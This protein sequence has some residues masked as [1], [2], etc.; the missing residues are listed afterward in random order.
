MT[1]I[2]PFGE[3]H[4]QY[5]TL[6]ESREWNSC[7]NGP[8]QELYMYGII[9][10]SYKFCDVHL[11]C[12]LICFTYHATHWMLTGANWNY[13]TSVNFKNL[14]FYLIKN[15][16]KIFYW[17]IWFTKRET[18]PE[19]RRQKHFK[20]SCLDADPDVWNVRFHINATGTEEAEQQPA[21][22]CRCCNC[23]KP[24]RCLL[25]GHCLTNKIVCIK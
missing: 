17:T 25:N 16:P 21:C 6:L 2:A 22:T 14:M 19:E 4:N 20:F 9:A 13:F 3:S 23:P 7:S 1:N 15:K 8:L 18:K 10:C 5:R 24:E 12:S 11:L